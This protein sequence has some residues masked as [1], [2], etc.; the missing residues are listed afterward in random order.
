M[1]LIGVNEMNT[2]EIWNCETP[3]AELLN[4]QVPECIE[5]D[6]CA[7]TIASICNGGCASGSYMPAVT[8]WQA[9][10]IMADYG[11]DVLDYIHSVVG[12]LPKVPSFESWRGMACLYLSCAVELWAGDIM[13]QLE[14][15][16]VAA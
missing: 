14:E 15:M 4:I 3:V 8:Y 11:D 13:G 7:M 12:E 6:I 1:F 9:N 16:E 5:Q 10:N 2:N